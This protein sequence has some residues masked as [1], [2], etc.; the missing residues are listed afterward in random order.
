MRVVE[1]LESQVLEETG[2][3][4]KL[5]WNP[6]FSAIVTNS[7]RT[8]FIQ[9]DETL[10]GPNTLH[11]V[12]QP[13]SPAGIRESHASSNRNKIVKLACLFYENNVV[14]YVLFWYSYCVRS[15][16]KVAG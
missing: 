5:P 7:D 14:F 3:I 15:E 4:K 11:L 12:S 8:I 10:P 1:G 16:S 9:I 13:Q 2:S 6:N